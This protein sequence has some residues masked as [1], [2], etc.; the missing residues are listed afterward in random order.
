[1]PYQYDSV[2]ENEITRLPHTTEETCPGHKRVHTRKV[3]AHVQVKATGE[4]YCTSC[5]FDR[6]MIP[7]GE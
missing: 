6:V 1:M 2:S 7:I 3:R 4:N 5:W